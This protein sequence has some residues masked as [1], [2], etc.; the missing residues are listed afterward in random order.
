MVRITEEARTQYL[1]LLRWYLAE[2]RPRAARN[3]EAAYG[4]AVER[5]ESSPAASL[6]FPR[7]YPSLARY[8]FRWIK[9]RRYWFAFADRGEDGPVIT[10]VFDE[11]ADMPGRVSEGDEPAHEA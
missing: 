3:L 6:A 5:I 11:T 1:R 2:G 4:A 8:G 10:N 9:E 7:P